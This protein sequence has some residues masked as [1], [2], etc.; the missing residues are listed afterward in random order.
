MKCIQKQ[1]IFPPLAGLDDSNDKIY[2]KIWYQRGTHHSQTLLHN[3][4]KFLTQNSALLTALP[5]PPY[6][7]HPGLSVVFTGYLY[8]GLSAMCSRPPPLCLSATCLHT[9]SDGRLGLLQAYLTRHDIF[10]EWASPH[11]HDHK[12]D[13]DHHNGHEHKCD[14]FAKDSSE[15]HQKFH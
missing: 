14:P 12:L 6:W 11:V 10:S 5:D 3:G 2:D 7:E 8:W 9:G 13:Q 1:A 4:G 15:T